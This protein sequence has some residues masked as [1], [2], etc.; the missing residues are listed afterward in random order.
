MKDMFM[1]CCGR[2]EVNHNKPYDSQCPGH[3]LNW[4]P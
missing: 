3:D 2:T 4:I 1:Y